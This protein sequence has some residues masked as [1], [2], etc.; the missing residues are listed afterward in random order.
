MNR[1]RFCEQKYFA[2]AVL[3]LT[4]LVLGCS[5]PPPSSVLY[6]S[7]T[8]YLQTWYPFLQDGK[9]TKA[10]IESELGKP[11]QQFEN[12]RLWTYQLIGGL[13]ALGNP[14]HSLVLVFDSEDVLRGH[15][16]IRI[17]HDRMYG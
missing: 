7:D 15:R 9:T 1:K 10:Q 2:F 6:A 16:M 12:G 11:S 4:G 5:A 13:T 3:M 14:Q 17:R 8:A